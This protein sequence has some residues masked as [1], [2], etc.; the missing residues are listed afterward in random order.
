[1][2]D[3]TMASEN[4][5]NIVSDA[6]ALNEVEVELS[7]VLGSASLRVSQLLKLGR[8][9]VVEL[10][11]MADEPVEVIANN[12]TLV[13]KGEVVVTDDDMVGISL[14]EV[15]HSRPT[16]A[17]SRLPLTKKWITQNV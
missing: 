3:K 13:A 6:D 12:D 11:R 2:E 15:V 4:I 14:T 5:K 17:A 16:N 7:V 9:A 10:D 8:G 1:V